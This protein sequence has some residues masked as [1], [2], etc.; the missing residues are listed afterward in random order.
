MAGEPQD[1][2]E[3]AYE[4]CKLQASSDGAFDEKLMRSWFD[5]AWKLCADMVGLAPPMEIK[6]PICIDDFGGFRLSHRP[7]SPVEI[8]DGY[9]LVATIP[10]DLYRSRCDP[11]LCCLCHP[12]AR[13]MIG[14]TTCEVTPT[15]IQAVARVFAYIVEN[16]GDSELDDQVLGKCGALAF[17][18][19]ELTFVL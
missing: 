11:A 3:Y 1:Q 15:F 14:S 7:S 8:F 9:T 4:I 13:Y 18:R 2:V 6:E 17:L 10:Q 5:A 12:Y 16:R 19:P